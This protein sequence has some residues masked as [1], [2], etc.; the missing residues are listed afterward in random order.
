MNKYKNYLEKNSYSIKSIP[1]YQKAKDRFNE[2]CATY[3]TTATE[4]DYKTFLQYIQHLKTTRIKP[5]TLKNYINNLRI[6]FNYL[7]ESNQRFENIIENINIKGVKTTVKQNTFTSDELENFYFEYKELY[8]TTLSEKRNRIIIGLLIYQGLTTRNIEDLKVENVQLYKGKLEILGTKK[9][10]GRTLELKPWQLMELM[11]Y[12]EKIRPQ[13]LEQKQKYSSLWEDA[14]GRWEDKLFL[15]LGKSKSLQNIFR[16]INKSLREINNKYINVNQIRTSV[17]IN[18]LSQYNLRKT[19]YFAGHRFI[20]STEKYQQD[21]MESLHETINLYHPLKSNQAMEQNL[22]ICYN[23]NT[24]VMDLQADIK[25]ISQELKTVKDPTLIEALKSM[26]KYRR[27]VTQSSERISLEQYNKEI[28]E[29]ITEVKN[30]E[31]YTQ[32][33]VEKMAEQW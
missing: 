2:W 7:V 29:A 17:I 22:Y 1:T 31:F 3:G 10:N 4:I 24:K 32:E 28:Q 14:E 11:E 33:E 25:W 13:F 5:R 9:S 30:G 15:T 6:Y 27:N 26:L 12:I 21:D 18:W 16:K 23:K 19:Q 20:S 8:N